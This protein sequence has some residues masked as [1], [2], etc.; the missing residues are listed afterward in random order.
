MPEPQAMFLLDNLLK[1]LPSELAQTAAGIKNVSDKL[2]VAK[3]AALGL[4]T[5]TPEMIKQLK[6]ASETGAD[7]R[8][9]LAAG[10][11]R[12]KIK[13]DMTAIQ[14]LIEETVNSFKDFEEV[15]DGEKTGKL[16]LSQ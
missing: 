11:V 7:P 10:R 14:S 1:N 4:S 16:I 2:L 15:G 8:A 6:A 12:A 3:A 5:I 13:N 9:G